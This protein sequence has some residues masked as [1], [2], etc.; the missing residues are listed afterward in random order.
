MP[1]RPI[2]TFTTD[3]GR[4]DAYAAEMQAAVRNGS[5]AASPGLKVGDKI[6]IR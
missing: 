5:A 1:A 4:T 2:V 6:D 3:F